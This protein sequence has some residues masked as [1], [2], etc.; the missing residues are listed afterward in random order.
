MNTEVEEIEKEI[1]HFNDRIKDLKI[2]VKEG[3]KNC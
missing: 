1:E 2:R 3:S